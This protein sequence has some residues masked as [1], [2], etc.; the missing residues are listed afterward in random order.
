MFGIECL[1]KVYGKGF[2][3]PGKEEKS[4]TKGE[5]LIKHPSSKSNISK[6]DLTKI[7]RSQNLSFTPLPAIAFLTTA[8]G[9]TYFMNEYHAVVAESNILEPKTPI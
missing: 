2:K 6:N 4:F 1:M 5:E 8:F 7:N 3:I 9:F